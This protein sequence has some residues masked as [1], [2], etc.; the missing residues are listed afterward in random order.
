MLT[1]AKCDRSVISENPRLHV[2]D[3]CAHKINGGLFKTFYGK[4]ASLFYFGRGALWHAIQSMHL[5]PSDTVLVPSYH[6]G[7]EIEAVSMAGAQ[8]RYYD[9]QEDLTIDVSDLKNRIDAGTRAILLIHYFGFPQ[10]VEEIKAICSTSNIMLV[11]DCSQ[12]LF[13][14]F[15]G[16]ALGTFGDMAIFSQRKTLPL[17]DGGALL[18]NNS[19]L[20]P[21][22]PAKRPSDYVAIKKTLGMLFR[23]MLNLNPHNELPYPFERMA[24]VINRLVARKS[25]IRYST[26]MEIDIDRCCLTMSGTSKQIMNR[27]RIEHVIQQRR[28]NYTRL[29]GHLTESPC[30]RIV[31]DQLP[32]GVC[33]LFFPVKIER[34]CR[35]D[36]QDRL[37]RAGI[38]TFVFG[39]ELHSSLPSN[40]FRNAVK[41]SQNILCLPV[42]QDLQPADMS[43][44]AET[45]LRTVRELDNAD[46][47]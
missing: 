15:N 33:P 36:M 14:S 37:Q 34:V 32:D 11:E 26:G 42:H 23:S 28:D 18:L 17:P 22:L 41:L 38:G 20:T 10:P 19:E 46:S 13:S 30:I 4:E 24:T 47:H 16:K 40:Q 7:V 25:G 12:A 39:E 43:F 29:L 31:R 27:T 21:A 45:L 1:P 6:C 9:V 5:S 2:S 35:R 3:L 8:L 44:I